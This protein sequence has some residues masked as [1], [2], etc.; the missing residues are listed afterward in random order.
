VSDKS[1]DAFAAALAAQAKVQTRKDV[2]NRH[3]AMEIVE[4]QGRRLPCGTKLNIGEREKLEPRDNNEHWRS[5]FDD[6]RMSGSVRLF[7]A[8]IES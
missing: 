2:G 7:E 3:T 6:V 1:L 5:A 4:N 8:V